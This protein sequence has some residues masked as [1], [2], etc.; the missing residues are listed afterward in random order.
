MK[1]LVA[2]SDH[3][4]YLW[5]VLVQIEHFKERGTLEDAHY[6]LY[7]QGP[8]PSPLAL[9]IARE[10]GAKMYFWRDPR[11]RKEYDPA[12]KPWLI[13]AYFRQFPGEVSKRYQYLDPDVMVIQDPEFYREIPAWSASCTDGYTGPGYLRGHGEDLWVDLCDLAGVAPEVAAKVPG[14]GAQWIVQD[15]DAQF[16]FD[17]ATTSEQ[18]WQRCKAQPKQEG[19]QYQVQ[20]WCAEMYATQLLALAYGF[21]VRSDPAMDFIWANGP[22]EAWSDFGYFHDAG[23]PEPNGRDF[24]KGEHQSSPFR[25]P[26]VVDPVSASSRYVDLIRRTV[27]SYPSVIW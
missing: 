12:M 27:D 14:V 22:A 5:Q 23:I 18:M 10:T 2:T 8:D 11:V 9:Q 26:L 20:A 21:P 13:G 3:P 19:Q 17:V 25:T 16:W 24:C 6:L 7:H 4:F 15:A 1:T